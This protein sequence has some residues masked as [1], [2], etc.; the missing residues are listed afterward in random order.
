MF[1]KVA[2]LCPFELPARVLDLN[3]LPFNCIVE[4][5]FQFYTYH[6]YGCTYDMVGFD[7]YVLSPSIGMPAENLTCRK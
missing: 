5:N 6:D 4:T 1:D 3:F 7:L 2:T